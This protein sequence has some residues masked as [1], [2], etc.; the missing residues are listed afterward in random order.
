MK[1]NFD[2]G[3]QVTPEFLNA[4]NSP[5]YSEDP[6]NDGEIPY[7]D[8][9]GIGLTA[10]INRAMGAEQSVANLVAAEVNRA[11]AAENGKEPSILHGQ[12]PRTGV[13][14]FRWVDAGGNGVDRDPADGLFNELTPPS[15]LALS[16]SSPG[17][18]VISWVIGLDRS[19]VV[20]SAAEVSVEIENP[21]EGAAAQ[22]RDKLLQS[23]EIIVPCVLSQPGVSKSK[24]LV[25]WIHANHY[26]PD[27]QPLRLILRNPA[28]ASWWYSYQDLVDDFPGV[29]LQ[30][31]RLDI[32]ASFLI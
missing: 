25:G 11:I 6:Q 28:S 27:P 7:P 26:L 22:L 23:A 18:C 15:R 32:H 3:T 9:E 19:L 12:I 21:E 17:I 14:G 8:A 29:L 5:V 2:H 31:M 16:A 4:I 20:G 13:S 30:P 10:E 24:Q 1:T